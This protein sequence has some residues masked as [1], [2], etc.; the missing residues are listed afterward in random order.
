MLLSQNLKIPRSD[1]LVKG[2]EFYQRP[3]DK[4]LLHN[5]MHVCHSKSQTIESIFLKAQCLKAK[6]GLDFVFIDFLTA[7]STQKRCDSEY[8]Q[9]NYIMQNTADIAA[10]LDVGVFLLAQLNR[11]VV[12]SKDRKPDLCH[13]K[14]SSAIENFADHVMFVHR[15]KITWPECNHDYLELLVRK[16]RYGERGSVFYKSLEGTIYDTNQREAKNETD[17]F[18]NNPNVENDFSL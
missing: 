15:D 8:A 1:F 6:F 18:L 3:L 9:I 11:G 10:Q 13:L 16:N 14:G 2:Q 5:N 4:L 7:L 12:N 17:A